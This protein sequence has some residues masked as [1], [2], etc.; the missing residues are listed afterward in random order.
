MTQLAWGEIYN[1]L[2]EQF[3][4]EIQL[5]ENTTNYECGCVPED[6]SLC[7]AGQFIEGLIS[8]EDLK[9]D[10]ELSEETE[11]NFRICTC[12]KKKMQE[13]FVFYNG[14]E[15]YCGEECLKTKYTSEE[16]KEAYENDQAY[17]TD[18]Y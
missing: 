6:M 3:K 11:D 10:Y 18:W 8:V 17:W 5:H 1:T 2:P 14:E 9:N 16:Y 13:G 7:V 4:K 15:Y 12:C